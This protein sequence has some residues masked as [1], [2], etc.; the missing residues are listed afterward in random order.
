MNIPIWKTAIKLCKF[1]SIHWLTM[2][3]YMATIHPFNVYMEHRC[4][5]TQCVSFVGCQPV[6]G[7]KLWNSHCLAL[8]YKCQTASSRASDAIPWLNH[9]LR[10]S[11]F[12]N[13]RT[14]TKL[15]L[16]QRILNR[17]MD[18]QVNSRR[19][20]CPKTRLYFIQESII[21][22]SIPLSYHTKHHA[23]IDQKCALSNDM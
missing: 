20:I 23:N 16:T 2:D 18:T 11:R 3:S 12:A 9:Y 7:A 15:C 10:S 8:V 21:V 14:K 22:H 4:L 1:C 6:I 5:C 13:I 17:V 19:Q